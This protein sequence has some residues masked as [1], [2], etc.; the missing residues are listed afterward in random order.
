MDL[1]IVFPAASQAEKS[2]S[3]LKDLEGKLVDMEIHT[4][5]EMGAIFDRTGTIIK[6]THGHYVLKEGR[7]HILNIT[8]YISGKSPSIYG[9]KVKRIV[10]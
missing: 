5:F 1:P 4:D 3:K 7:K 6:N 10:A 2:I 8:K 9:V